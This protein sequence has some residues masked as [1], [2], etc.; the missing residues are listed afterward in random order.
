MTIFLVLIGFLLFLRNSSAYKYLII[1]F[2]FTAL[3]SIILFKFLSNLSNTEVM[4]IYVRIIGIMILYT[5]FYSE[6]TPENL[7]KSLMYFKIPYRYA[8]TISTSYRYIFLIANDSRDIKN[9]LL[10]RGVPLDGSIL[11]RIR[12]IPF[13][14]NLLLFRTN[15]LSM[16]FAEALFSK[17]WTPFGTK[18]VLHPLKFFQKENIPIFLLL[19]FLVIDSFIRFGGNL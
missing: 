5:L 10:I 19:L 2:L 14:I 3:M 12:N 15:Y 9:A 6:I 1:L 16:K 13:V 8:W 11:D 18:T 17:N 7:T 4:V